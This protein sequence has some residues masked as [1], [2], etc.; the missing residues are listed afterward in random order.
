MG[1]FDTVNFWPKF[2]GCPEG[3]PETAGKRRTSIVR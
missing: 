2:Q 1:M 3:L